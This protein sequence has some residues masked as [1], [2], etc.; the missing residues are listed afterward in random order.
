M[1]TPPSALGWSPRILVD[2]TK[3]RSTRGMEILS[4]A[5]EA[6]LGHSEFQNRPRNDRYYR[7]KN[8]T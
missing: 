8:F 1:S 4:Q 2:H 7:V 6:H 5:L 3:D